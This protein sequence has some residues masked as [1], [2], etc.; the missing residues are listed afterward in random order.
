[1]AGYHLRDIPRGEVGEV[2]KILEEVIEL[3]DAVEQG[4][5]VMQLCELSDIVQAIRMHLRKHHPSISL[6][7]LIMMADVTERAF[8]DGSRVDKNSLKN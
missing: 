5:V 4:V 7:D 6:N 2:S 8:K 3:E 1:M